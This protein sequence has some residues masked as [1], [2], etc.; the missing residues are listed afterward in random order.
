LAL[1]RSNI[2]PMRR[3]PIG[4]INGFI[5]G[6]SGIYICDNAHFWHIY[7]RI[8]TYN[9]MRGAEILDPVIARPGGQHSKYYGDGLAS[10]VVRRK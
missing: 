3:R 4:N 2:A 9:P 1:L 7:E 10:A 8:F 5:P 6:I